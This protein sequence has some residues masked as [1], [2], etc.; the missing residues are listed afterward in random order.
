MFSRESSWF[1]HSR[2]TEDSLKQGIACVV[3][4]A[5]ATV[6]VFQGEVA[7]SLN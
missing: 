1:G 4:I 6:S 2:G 5:F 7:W 3:W